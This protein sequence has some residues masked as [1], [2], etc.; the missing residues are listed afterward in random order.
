MRVNATDAMG[1]GRTANS[2]VL[3]IEDDDSTGPTITLTD[4]EGAEIAA[5][6]M[7][8]QDQQFFWSIGDSSGSS[9]DVTITKNSQEIFARSYTADVSEDSFDFNAYGV[10]SY[11]ITINTTDKDNDRTG[12]EESSTLSQIVNVLNSSPIAAMSVTTEV[13]GRLEGSQIAFSATDSS[14]PESDAMTYVWNFGDG[15]IVRGETPS[16]T[17]R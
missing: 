4:S 13:A 11:Q 15:V 12:D 3:I 6:Q 5:T 17:L 14:D 7:A 2:G 8:G 10:G 16:S 1:L 9:S